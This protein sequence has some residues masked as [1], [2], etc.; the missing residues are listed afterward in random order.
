MKNNFK[1][2]YEAS[3]EGILVVSI[4]GSVVYCNPRL[5][6]ICAFPSS[7][8]IYIQELLLQ[9]PP[10]RA[11]S[12]LLEIKQYATN[13]PLTLRVTTTIIEKYII[14]HLSDETEH[15]EQEL[16]QVALFHI[17]S[18]TA[19]A[20]D[21]PDCYAAIHSIVGELMEAKNFYIATYNPDTEMMTFE[22]HVDEY[23]KCPPPLPMDSGL[24]AYVIRSGEPYFYSVDKEAIRRDNVQ[25]IG[26][27]S[28]DWIGVPL[29]IGT[30]T[31]GAMVIQSY[32]ETVRFTE[33]EK[34]LLQFVA[35]HIAI[36][37][38][39]KRI[40]AQLKSLSLYDEL[41]HLYNRRGFL[42][43]GAQQIKIAFRNK[44]EM[45]LFFFDLDN[46]K[47][48]NDKYGHNAGDTALRATSSVLKT[49]FRDADIIARLGGD[50]FVVL[51]VGSDH[52]Q[53]DSL[54]KRISTG[55]ATFNHTHEVPF[56][57]E[58]SVGTAVYYP[59]KETSIE[60][61]LAHADELMYEEK[62]KRKGI[63]TDE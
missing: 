61:L 4:E 56:P 2:Y 18:L 3:F 10:D 60:D 45:L 37:I 7:D 22:Y 25:L 30:R 39:R 17:S 36:A 40:E 5:I 55:F 54:R 14:Y 19:L 59:E 1:D 26:H 52:Y 35:Q 47:P 44:K 41:T 34:N 31:H 46:M 33:R 21:M 53:I 29:K 32:T 48:I 15:R 28:I 9:I 42:T 51:A 12:Y 20:D 23:D 63:T 49:V 38:E 13:I 24:T 57:L 62:K 16:L 58:V 43:L 50:E 11:S 27:Q 6:E 8:D